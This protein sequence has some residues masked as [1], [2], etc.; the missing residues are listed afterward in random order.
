[1][2]C[3]LIHSKKLNGIHLPEVDRR[4]T[5]ESAGLQL[6]PRKTVPLS[7][8][9]PWMWKQ[10]FPS[11][12]IAAP[13][14]VSD[15]NES[16]PNW[17]LST[18]NSR[19]ISQYAMKTF[20]TLKRDFRGLYASKSKVKKR[21]R[22]Q[23][24]ET[25][26]VETLNGQP[27]IPLA[28]VAS[29][30]VDAVRPSTAPAGTVEN[31]AQVSADHFQE[32]GAQAVQSTRAGDDLDSPMEDQSDI[33]RPLSVIGAIN[34]PS[35][36]A[37][38]SIQAPDENFHLEE[39]RASAVKPS[40]DS[41]ASGLVALSDAKVAISTAEETGGPNESSHQEPAPESEE[42]VQS[43]TF[44]EAQEMRDPFYVT[45]NVEERE[46]YTEG[47][48]RFILAADGVKDCVAMLM[49]FDLSQVIQE[50][51]RAQREYTR[52]ETLGLFHRQSLWR[53]EHGIQREIASCNTRLAIMEEEGRLQSG[54]AHKLE[55]QLANLE[56]MVPDVQSR[57]E[58]THADLDSQARALR[59]LQADV[60][61]H[62]ED[63]FIH[64]HLL[65][66]EEEES[67]P[68]I[69][70]LDLAREYEI[71]CRKLENA[72]DN[73]SD[74]TIPPLDTNREHPEVPPPSEEDQARQQVINALWAAKET[75]DLA[76][77]DFEERETTRAREFQENQAAAD[78][79]EPTIDATPDD[80]DMRWVLRY[81][82]LTRDLINAEAEYAE[83]KR[84]A[85]EAG[86]PLSFEDNE[87]V[88]EAMDEDEGVGYTISKEQELAASIPS[89]TVR[90]WLDEVPEG[91]EVGSPSF[92]DGARSE[93]D[94]WEAEE[95]GISDSVS[96]VAE[97]RE[98]ARI[99][100]WRKVCVG[101]KQE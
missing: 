2:G 66:E 4:T 19:H 94:E 82:E 63:A 98:R 45:F 91:V 40:D 51:I 73:H 8:R 46:D 56:L 39:G 99:D 75:L 14:T 22:A 100:R 36:P 67:E 9:V 16:G 21:G 88:C 44:E 62:L 80:F 26:A 84:T 74:V 65:A 90:R 64:A 38:G 53:L 35:S 10:L 11:I 77:R 71:F 29:Q 17:N 12:S 23:T 3:N 76:R 87:T 97:G 43:F 89:P 33:K 69:E 52:I 83:V 59:N 55:R 49:T 61:A 81:G 28:S 92:G 27:D 42:G 41:T 30:P 5:K 32:P 79:G 96:L 78:R 48:A 1:M 37:Q 85:F 58:R 54:D 6:T 20:E 86:V 101:E 95:V 13:H 7:F 57:R 60:N 47:P 24:L 72:N 31:F 93:S 34:S 70:E 68:E 25:G 50:S 18:P 15:I